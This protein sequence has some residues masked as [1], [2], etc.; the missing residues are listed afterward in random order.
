MLVWHVIW[1][2]VD[3]EQS[4]RRIDVQFDVVHDGALDAR[5]KQVLLDCLLQDPKHSWLHYLDERQALRVC[6]APAPRFPTRG[7]A[8]A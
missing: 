8:S 5:E 2:E 7:N 1:K 3:H 4:V 6:L